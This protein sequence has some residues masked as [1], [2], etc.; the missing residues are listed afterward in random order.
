METCFLD[1][2]EGTPRF[3]AACRCGEA[4]RGARPGE[5]EARAKN[6]LANVLLDNK[7]KHIKHILNNH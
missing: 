3:L 7:K 4:R 2:A 6:M 1:G 5:R